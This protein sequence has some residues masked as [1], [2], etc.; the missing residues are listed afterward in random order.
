M[1]ASVDALRDAIKL[2]GTD[3]PGL[4]SANPPAQ[5]V[6]NFR[7]RLF[8]IWEISQKTASVQPV[9][10]MQ[11]EKILQETLW[12]VQKKCPLEGGLN[13]TTL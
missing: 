10:E 8:D 6:T 5:S 13:T 7:S 9:R 3:I 2:S 4:G 12:P 11:L 1:E